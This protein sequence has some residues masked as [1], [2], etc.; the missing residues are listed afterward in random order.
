MI[1]ATSIIFSISACAQIPVYTSI[2]SADK[3]IFAGVK[4]NIKGEEPDTYLLQVDSQ[5]LLSSKVELPAE[6]SSREII[7]LLPT[8]G[9]ELV[10]VTQRTVEQGD[11]PQ[12]HSY[13]PNKK[14][15]KKLGESK[16]VSFAKLSVTENSL[17]MSCVETNEKGEE[18]TK[19][20]Q[21][22][23]SGLKLKPV[24]TLE[25]PQTK[26]EDKNL[27][28]QL[29]GESFEWKELKIGAMGQE[30]IFKP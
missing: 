13:E 18:V 20:V 11:H 15:W 29:V 19:P 3:N 2:A 30:K 25:L 14:E 28:A 6:L 17:T 27:K 23:I 10:V 16:C 7:A 12:I 4:K 22:K 5:K 1:I 24:K 8:Q 9:T 26:V 21:T